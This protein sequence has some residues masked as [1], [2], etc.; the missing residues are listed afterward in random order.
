MGA[1]IGVTL[2]VIDDSGNDASAAPT[3]QVVDD[4]D[5]IAACVAGPIPLALD[6]TGNATLDINAV[7]NGS[8]DNCTV[9]P[10]LQI[11][12]TDF[13]CADVGMFPTVTL[14]VTDDAGNE[15][16]CDAQVE[17]LDVTP[18]VITLLGGA[19]EAVTQNMT[20]TDPGVLVADVCDLG[21]TPIAGGFVNTS[22]LGPYLLTYDAVDASGNNAIQVTRTVTVVPDNPPV[23][24]LTG[25][26]PL[27]FECG[28]PGGYTDPGATANDLENGPLTPAILSNNVQAGVLGQYVVT[29]TVTDSFP[30]TVTLNRIVNVVDTTPPVITDIA[31]LESRECSIGYTRNDAVAAVGI[32]DLCNVPPASALVIEARDSQNAV[33]SFPISALGQYTITYTITDLSLNTSVPLVRT[34]DII[35][36]TPPVLVDVEGPQTIECPGPYT[37]AAARSTVTITD[38]CATILNDELT[39]TVTR[40][41]LPESF[42]LTEVGVYTLS[43]AATDTE[44]NTGTTLRTV[45]ISDTIRPVV[46]LIGAS[47][48]VVFK[49]TSF[50]DPGATASDSCAGGL[51]V[52]IGGDV[53]NVNAEGDYFVTYD[54][55]DPSGNNAVQVVRRV[56]VTSFGGP[57][58][59]V[60]PPVDRTVDYNANTTFVVVANAQGALS[61]QWQKDSV[62]LSNDATYAGVTTATLAITGAE[63]ADEGNYRVVVSNPDGSVT[64]STAR[65]TVNDPAIVLQPQDQAVGINS[66][67]TFTVGAVGSGTLTYRWYRAPNTPLTD[68]AKFSGVTTDTLSILNTQIVDE[69]IFFR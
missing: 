4:V 7:N 39:V 49:G 3:V 24:T 5:P 17:V 44:G 42:P 2:T 10:A 45:T 56:T 34:I 30:T 65:L 67:A 26:N 20:Y 48:V 66:T 68:G 27:T 52:T 32:S 43:Y 33:V 37:L 29:W 55:Q 21:V 62:A 28:T 63:N 35:D 57:P 61:Y 14:T 46:S 23:I 15:S 38:N 31:G 19:L 12:R 11:S 6:D 59:I 8:S 9:V 22:V 64:S 53:V 13:T 51:P 50:T 25:A 40:N 47:T 54:A 41:A 18:P 16:T 36:T 60:S 58:I 1:P 69:A